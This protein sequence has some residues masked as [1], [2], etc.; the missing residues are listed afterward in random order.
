MKTIGAKE[1]RLHLEEILD[2][3]LRGEDVIVQHR[4]KKPVRISA[5]HEPVRKDKK[6]SG[7]QA[8]DNAEKRPSPFDQNK[9]IKELYA[10]SIRRKY[11]A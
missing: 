6:L 7:L 5:L 2:R 3:V 11:T 4:F 10:E 9:S 1:L 8:F